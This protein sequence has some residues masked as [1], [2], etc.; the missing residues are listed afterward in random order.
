MTR[1]PGKSECR[2]GRTV[3]AISSKRTP[4]PSLP[5]IPPPCSKTWINLD[6]FGWLNAIG[7]IQCRAD[8]AA[9]LARLRRQMRREQ[10]SM[11]TRRRWPTCSRCRRETQ[12]QQDCR[13]RWST[14]PT[15]R[16]KPGQY[17]K[18]VADH[19]THELVDFSQVGAKLGR[20]GHCAMTQSAR[21]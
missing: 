20:K 12:S 11:R 8:V 6:I 9:G 15:N 16:K 14:R 21:R 17:R 13:W 18:T 19:R 2:S 7:Y 4:S 1:T 5:G 10:C 3:A